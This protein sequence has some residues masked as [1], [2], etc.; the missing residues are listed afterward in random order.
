MEPMVTWFNLLVVL[1]ATIVVFLIMGSGGDSDPVSLNPRNAECPRC[2]EWRVRPGR[3][4]NLCF[5]CTNED[6]A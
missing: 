2:H 4:G 6:P 1:A 5:T 3:A